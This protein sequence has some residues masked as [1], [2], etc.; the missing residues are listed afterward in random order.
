MLNN[1]DKFK[2]PIGLSVVGIVL[3]LGGIFTSSKPQREYPKESLVNTQ[4]LVSVD[5]SGAVN[6][7]GVYQVKDGSRVEDV[8]KAAGG[9]AENANQEYI[10]KYLNLAQKLVDGSKIFVPFAGENASAPL[11]AVPNE[12][13]VN[14]NTASQAQLEAL[15]GIGPTT[16][17]KIISLRPYQTIEDILNKKAVSKSV[18]EKIKDQLLL[19]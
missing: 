16:A 4:K 5:V 15:P 6:K 9:F 14:I 10:S 13:K 1:I 18:Y 2:L 7:P 19:Y 3:I 17:A 11:G 12:S 8:I